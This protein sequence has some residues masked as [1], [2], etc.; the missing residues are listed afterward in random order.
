MGQEMPGG[1]WAEFCVNIPLQRSANKSV[2][3]I[4][5]QNYRSKSFVNVTFII[6]L[7]IPCLF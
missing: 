7:Y 2:S 1:K 4:I 6:D 3:S 5:R